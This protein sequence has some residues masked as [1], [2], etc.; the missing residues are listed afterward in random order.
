M[1]GP[2]WP[3]NY[4]GG[5]GYA[6]PPAY[7]PYGGVAV[8][9]PAAPIEQVYI[10]QPQEAVVPT[11]SQPRSGHWYYCSSPAGYYPDVNTCSRPWIAVDPRSG[12]RAG[13][14]QQVA[15]T[16]RR[17]GPIAARPRTLTMTSH[18]RAFALGALALGGLRRGAAGA[19]GRGDAGHEQVAGPVPGRQRQLPAVRAI[20]DRRAD[21]GRATIRPAPT[22]SAARRLGALIGAAFG[23]VTGD[24]GYGAA[25]GAGTG[26]MFGSAGASNYGA[27]S[28]YT[29]QQQYNAA[30][31]QCMY[32]QGNQVPGRVVQRRYSTTVPGYAP[33]VYQV[34]ADATPAPRGTPPPVTYSVPSDAI[35]PPPGTP[36]PQ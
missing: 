13:G 2:W 9:V 28:S 8:A 10:Q 33:R 21:E 12:R 6:Y 30:Y 5:V 32:T 29:L 24:A 22:S 23:S 19:D 17:A 35:A 15:P 36:A 1:A 7:Y 26:A 27:V 25:W 3:A 11:P 4:W 34:P 18:E 16:W 14:C 31:M 20:G